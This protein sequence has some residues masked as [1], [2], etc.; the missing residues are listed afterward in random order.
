[1]SLP[2]FLSKSCARVQEPSDHL[3]RDRIW[4]CLDRG[5]VID[6]CAGVK[7]G[8]AEETE[9]EG[10][11]F[12]SKVIAQREAGVVKYELGTL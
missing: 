6:P 8:G 5:E 1:M 2:P 4:I 12:P 10:T 3:A 9:I 7:G 11:K